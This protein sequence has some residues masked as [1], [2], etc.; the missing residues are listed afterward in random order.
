MYDRYQGLIFDMDGTLLDTEEGH[1]KAWDEVLAKYGMKLDLEGAIALNGSPSWKIAEFVIDS[2]QVDMD[3]HRLA[4]EKFAIVEEIVLDMVKPLPIV[5][6]VK[7]YRGRRP[8][9]VGTGS[10]HGFADRLLQHVGLRD[11]FTAIVGADDVVNHKPAPD[12]FLACASLMK[13]TAEGCIVFE[14]APLGLQ[15]AKAAGMD[16]VDV[17]TL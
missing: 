9:A 16:A 14:D 7:H 1:R 11:Y 15:A 17:R 13:V 4:Q 3:P 2:Y 8:M 5:E 12:T 6:V 10:M